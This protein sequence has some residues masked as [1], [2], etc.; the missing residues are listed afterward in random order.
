MVLLLVRPG[1]V[2]AW[3]REPG[4][5]DDDP[6]GVAFGLACADGEL[7][8]A[9]VALPLCAEPV[10]PGAVDEAPGLDGLVVPSWLVPVVG[11][12]ALVA[13]LEPWVELPP[14]PVPVRVW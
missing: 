5:V 10:W 12:V 2:P 11:V 8:G 7:D 1:A 14:W 4:S 9:V 6:G 13:P 3:E